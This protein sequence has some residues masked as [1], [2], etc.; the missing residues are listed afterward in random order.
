ML[1]D[2]RY[3]LRSLARAKGFTAT[4]VF[5]LA[6]GIGSAA[7][8][9]NLVDWVLFRSVDFPEGLVMLGTRDK[10]GEFGVI[11]Y[12]AETR[13]YR[14]LETVFETLAWARFEAASIVVR[15]EPVGTGVT[16][17]SSNF[18]PVIG[19]QLALGRGFRPDEASAGRDEV[20]VISHS[21]WQEQLQG[22]ADVLERDLIVGRSACKIVG[23]L[24]RDQVLPTFTQ[25][26]VLR[27]LVDQPDPEAPWADWRFVFGRLRNGV[28]REQAEAAMAATA[29]EWP[30]RMQSMAADRQPA[31]RTM[32]ELQK[33]MRPE[34]YWI[35]VGAVG[36]LYAIACLNATNL[37]LVRML[38]RRRELSIRLALGGGAWRLARLSALEG[39]LLSLAG[40]V[41]G[42]GV[43]N[44]LAP[45]LIA[46]AWREGGVVW[47]KWSLDGRPLVVLAAL[48]ALTGLAVS[49]VPVLR[50]S[51]VNVQDGLKDGG[52]ALGESRGL[53]R[54][55]GGLVI[56]QAAF[57]VVLLAGAGLMMRTFQRLQ[58]VPLGFDPSHLVRLQIGF[59]ER[60]LGG[61]EER[62]AWMRRLEEHLKHLPGVRSVAY[63]SGVLLPGYVNRGT[64]L[65]LGDGS[66]LEVGMDA[67]SPDYLTVAGVTLQ[68]GQLPRS[69][70]LG[71]VAINEALARR[72]FGDEDPIGQYL[73]PEGATGD[74]KGWQV[75][76]VVA[77][78]R[79]T[80]RALPGYH[81]YWP[82][83]AHPQNLFVFILRTIRP[84]DAALIAAAKRAVYEFDPQVVTF[85]AET[86]EAARGQQA[87]GERFALTVLR[88]LAGIA[89]CLTVVGLF[90]VLA[91]AVDRRMNEFGVRLALGATPRDLIRLVL[92][93]GIALAAAGMVSG[94]A[95]ALG[96]A[97]F[98]QSLLYETAP[99]D[100][101]VLGGVSLVL[102]AA[103]ALACVLPARRAT[104]VD[105]AK[106]L[107]SE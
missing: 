4:I 72:R 6:L 37:L 92:R 27:P 26:Q 90:S 13:A 41:L 95:G 76:G 49:L 58:A 39:L 81:V 51:W 62:L 106:L 24:R 34:V 88:V 16:R 83:T 66:V 46:M 104:K 28:S 7:A 14:A 101:W 18:L 75:V 25:G 96:L 98:L 57:A 55:R 59:P 85:M 50:M 68:R 9:F 70:S 23:V 53:A 33:F 12:D 44:W 11:Q 87:W 42:L 38:G 71:E 30:T 3:V 69:G 43:A 22:A 82:E 67:M 1:A 79:E 36:L 17:I 56:G 45:L 77:N 100:P 32:Q 21:F 19:A 99:H 60:Y 97:R 89:L 8:V 10:R 31:I 74:W 105:V 73:K 78:L 47:L 2:L 48:G 5:T 80:L 20:V 93:R 84:P 29:I 40:S 61:N 65:Q 94:L 52:A 107:R 64:K 91:Y 63:G 102:L 15:D 86:L 103:A 35:L 54:L